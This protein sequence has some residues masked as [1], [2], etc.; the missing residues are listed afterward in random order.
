M[1]WFRL[2]LFAIGATVAAV[3]QAEVIKLR[4]DEYYPFNGAQSA[5]KPGYVVE[6]AK[7][8][9]EPLGHTI[10]YQ[11]MP[12]A[13]AIREAEAGR[14]DGLVCAA[15]SEVPQF[16]FPEEPQGILRD[17]IFT[18]KGSTWKYSGVASLKLV[19]V[20]YISGYS[21]GPTFD[22]YIEA[23]KGDPKLLHANTGDEALVQN[24]E[25]LQRGRLSALLSNPEV[26]LATL[27][28]HHLSA[29]Q[30]QLAGVSPNLDPTYI[31][32]SP[33]NPKASEY[34]RI[35]SE[36]TQR[37]RKSGELTRILSRYGLADWKSPSVFH[38]VAGSSQHPSGS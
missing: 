34:A 11:V 22:E 1:R 17:A 5:S 28:D 30:F 20:G 38:A 37:L 9:F 2:F 16:I 6:V 10:D 24:I 26:F 25:M 31:A 35:L 14:I 21:Y 32:F 15:K 33:K 29:E 8:I 27:Q 36:G 4:A 18:L 13:R 12:W 23:N 19:V 3:A 7:A